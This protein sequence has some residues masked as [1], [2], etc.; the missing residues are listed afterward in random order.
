[1]SFASQ[2]RGFVQKIEESR[3]NKCTGSSATWWKFCA[4]RKQVVPVILGSPPRDFSW[5]IKEGTRLIETGWEV[6]RLVILSFVVGGRWLSFLAPASSRLA[7]LGRQA[8]VDESPPPVTFRSVSLISR[9]ENCF[10]CYDRGR[11]RNQMSRD[12]CRNQTRRNWNWSFPSSILK[13]VVNFS[14]ASFWI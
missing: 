6:S 8:V 7:K 4:R 2:R 3:G 12:V 13:S 9:R 10:S 11:L 14:R 1:M 5:G